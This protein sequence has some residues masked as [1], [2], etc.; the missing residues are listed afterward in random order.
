MNNELFHDYTE[1]EWQDA[2]KAMIETPECFEKERLEA[3]D[4]YCDVRDYLPPGTS[5]KKRM[6]GYVSIPF[7]EKIVRMKSRSKA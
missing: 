4:H 1:K 2:L 3:W 5:Y 7:D 6:F